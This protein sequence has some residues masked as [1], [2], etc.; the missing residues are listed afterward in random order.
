MSHSCPSCGAPDQGVP[1]CVS[2]LMP[3]HGSLSTPSGTVSV[4]FV[5]RQQAVKAGFFRRFAAFAI[6]WLILSVLADIV[7]FAYR[8]GSRT[9]P[10]MMQLDMALAISTVL[11]FLYFT[12]FIGDGGRTP[13]KMLMGIK[14]QRIDGSAVSYGRAFLRS[15]GYIVSMFFM[16][17]LGFI[18]ALWDRKKQAWHDKIAGTEVIKI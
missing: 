10:G 4:Q 14:V 18:W 8:S 2:C 7:R 15:L 3:L 16:T 17:F 1:F 12:L 5:T 9:D 13:G 11:F 6:D